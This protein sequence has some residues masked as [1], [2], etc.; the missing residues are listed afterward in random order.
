MSTAFRLNDAFSRDEIRRFSA[1]SDLAGWWA[2]G[3]TWALIAASF[4]VMAIWPHPLTVLLGLIVLGGRQLALSILMHEGAHYSLFKTR[5]LND[6]VADWLCARLVWNDVKRYRRHHIQHH[7]HT[8]SDLDPD[9][10]LV[11]PFPTTRKSL[12]RKIVR[13]LIGRTALKRVLGLFLMDIGALTYT[14]SGGAR[15]VPRNGRSIASYAAE[16]LRNM[17]PMLATNAALALV[18]WAFG[19]GWTYWV[20]IAAY[21]TTYSLFIRIRALAEHACTE[22]SDHPLRNTRTTRAGILARLTVA[23]IHVNY[24]LEHHLMPSAAWYHLP[25]MH[26]VLRERNSIGPAPSYPDVLRTVTAKAG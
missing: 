15:L 18:L 8:N 7:S 25:R 17:G 22:M 24:H 14:V 13:D 3:G 5:V 21:M 26:R 16:G 2:V 9:L 1:K 11:A 10:S 6:I 12:R 23:P 20:W 19:A 4:A